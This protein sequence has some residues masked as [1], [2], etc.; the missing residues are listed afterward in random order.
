MLLQSGLTA[1]QCGDPGDPFYLMRI[2]PATLPPDHIV[3]EYQTRSR[4]R[5]KR[6]S[7]YGVYKPQQMIP[8]KFDGEKAMYGSCTANSFS[9][10]HIKWN[11][12]YQF[13][14]AFEK[15]GA[16]PPITVGGFYMPRYGGSSKSFDPNKNYLGFVIMAVHAKGQWYTDHS[17]TF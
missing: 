7:E 17:K 5:P 9:K 10:Y 3:K 13:Y 2:M 14:S 12:N 11:T 4:P 6:R 15:N 1:T 16:L 8:V